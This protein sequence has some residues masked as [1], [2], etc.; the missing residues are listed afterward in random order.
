MKNG[1]ELA[2]IVEAGLNKDSSKVLNYTLFLIEKLEKDG[3]FDFANRLKS[4]VQRT[5]K[6]ELKTMNSSLS[7]LKP[8]VDQESRLPLA[9]IYTPSEN[10]IFLCMNIWSK[11]MIEDF[12]GL[13]NKSDELSDKIDVYRSIL[14]YG[15]PGT[16]KSQSAKYIST[17][18]KL[19]LVT[20]R[21]DGLVSSYLGSTSKNIRALFEF[22]KQTPCILFLDEFDAIAKMRD[23]S[24]ELGEL[25]RV[26]NT[27]LQNIDGIKGI[28]PIIA[29]TNHDHL[30][31]PAVWRR[32]D[33]KIKFDL[34]NKEERFL[35]FRHFLKN[36]TISEKTLKLLKEI[37]DKMNGA[38]IENF[39]EYILTNSLLKKIDYFDEK[40]TFDLFVKY[41]TE[42]KNFVDDEGF[43]KEKI[44][45]IKKMRQ[46]NSKFFN[47]ELSSKIL[48]CSKSTIFEKLKKEEG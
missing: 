6:I 42:G 7:I 27:L 35:L 40:R 14:L 20:I 22:V 47:Y 1:P 37:S 11:E 38:E 17:K 13:I 28:V 36:V 30:L 10:D 4:I 44:L 18:T 45:M 33:F 8:P 29:A 5:K 26:V 12:I 48:G 25:K 21:I 15:P 16:G 46:Q 39:C 9:E 31:D 19:P 32:F 23:D 43:K 41:R 2:K 3:D 34:P 24:H